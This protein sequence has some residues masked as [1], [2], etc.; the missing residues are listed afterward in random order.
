MDT[1]EAMT[2]AADA[3]RARARL[4]EARART[5]RDRFTGTED[6]YLDGARLLEAEARDDRAAADEVDRLIGT[7]DRPAG[8]RV[9]VG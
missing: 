7:I 2:R 9:V 6:K 1:R 5:L 8:P 3:L 4:D